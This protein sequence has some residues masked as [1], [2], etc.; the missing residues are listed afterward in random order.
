QHRGAYVY[1]GAYY[2]VRTPVCAVVAFVKSLKV[3]WIGFRDR[4]YY[5]SLFI[6][7]AK[8]YKHFCLPMEQISQIG[9]SR[10]QKLRKGYLREILVADN[11]I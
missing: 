4:V 8:M 1:L 3:L 7:I 2:L 5:T 9:K 10:C 11:T 6:Y